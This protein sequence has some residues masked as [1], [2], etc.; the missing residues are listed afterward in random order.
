[1]NG[2]IRTAILAGTAFMLW[3]LRHE[4]YLI[5]LIASACTIG[6]VYSLASWMHDEQQKRGNK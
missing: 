1:M 2:G 5:N 6:T 3:P 4:L